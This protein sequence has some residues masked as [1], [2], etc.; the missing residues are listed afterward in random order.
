MILLKDEP[1]LAKEMLILA[2]KN[3]S[4]SIFSFLALL[5]TACAGPATEYCLQAK[6]W[7]V[8][9]KRGKDEAIRL[10]YFIQPEK[11]K[12]VF[13]KIKKDNKA[14]KFGLV[15]KIANYVKALPY[16]E[17][18]KDFWNYVDETIEN[19]GDCED[20]AH[21]LASLLI[22][23]GF[24]DVYAIKGELKKG[25]LK[26]RRGHVWVEI[27]LNEKFYILETLK[28]YPLMQEK[29]KTAGYFSFF[30]YNNKESFY[31]KERD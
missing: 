4:I 24:R 2:V 23:V 31:I 18:E 10:T 15:K 16:K 5:L 30:K 1:N 19:G 7:Q 29:R 14:D 22:S 12:E 27:I 25:F 6:D 13:L 17:E 11:T 26:K 28:G 3:F 21:L 9:N 20:K 8:K